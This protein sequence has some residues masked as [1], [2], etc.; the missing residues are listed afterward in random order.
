[1]KTI[2]LTS[3]CSGGHVQPLAIVLLIYAYNADAPDNRPA[4]AWWEA[5]MTGR[6][7]SEDP[8]TTELWVRVDPIEAG[9][10]VIHVGFNQIG[11][12]EQYCEAST[13]SGNCRLEVDLPQHTAP[14]E[15]AD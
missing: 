7:P 8:F 13:Y 5:E 3:G 14:S 4:R 12:K 1:M 2:L 6:S 9:K 15:F 11:A 10:I